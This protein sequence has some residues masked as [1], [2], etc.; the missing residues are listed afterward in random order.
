MKL[1]IFLLII[2]SVLYANIAKI[3]MLKGNVEIHRHNM[4]LKGDIGLVIRAK[5]MI[6]IKEASSLQLTLRDKTVI[7]IGENSN[8]D[9]SKYLLEEEKVIG[10]QLSPNKMILRT[11]TK[12]VNKLNPNKVT[13][14]T[15]SASIGIRGFSN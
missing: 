5:D 2:T 13:L 9:F 11:I 12:T 4:I 15:P 10:D 3:T 14:D 6:L 7:T 8:F 1:I